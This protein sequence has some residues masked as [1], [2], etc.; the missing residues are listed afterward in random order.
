MLNSFS[1][2]IGRKHRKMA[3]RTVNGL[4]LIGDGQHITRI[5]SVIFYDIS[6]TWPDS[7]ASQIMLS[8][9]SIFQGSFISSITRAAVL[10]SSAQG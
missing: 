6:I 10:S 1:D 3:S 2:F 9:A 8:L 5:A 4:S 7:C